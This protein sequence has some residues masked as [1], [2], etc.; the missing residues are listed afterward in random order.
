MHHGKIVEFPIE[1]YKH[2]LK[3]VDVGVDLEAMTDLKTKLNV[4][5]AY[6]DFL[7]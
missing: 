6:L 2:L 4:H 7:I 1:L 3:F 5:T